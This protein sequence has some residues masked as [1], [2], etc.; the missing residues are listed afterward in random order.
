MVTSIFLMWVCTSRDVHV[1][2]VLNSGIRNGMHWFWHTDVTF[3]FS[4]EN[5]QCVTNKTVKPRGNYTMNNHDHLPYPMYHPCHVSRTKN[6]PEK[7]LEKNHPTC[8]RLPWWS[9]WEKRDTNH[10]GSDSELLNSLFQCSTHTSQNFRVLCLGHWNQHK[11]T[12]F[13]VFM[14]SI[15]A[16]Q[17]VPTAAMLCRLRLLRNSVN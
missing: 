17:F 13:L 9:N 16:N 10:D 5:A 12:S 4:S 14:A 8:R 1:L 3:W 6:E 11:F 15:R 7:T 2:G